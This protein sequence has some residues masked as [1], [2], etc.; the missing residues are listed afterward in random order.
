VRLFR[1]RFSGQ[2]DIYGTYDP[3][4]G[5]SWQVKAPVT[6]E[7][8]LDHLQGKRPY[9]VYLLLGDLTRAAVVDFDV[10]EFGPVLECV[11]RAQHYE[12]AMHIE[13]SKSKGFHVWSFFP[14]PGV[15]AWK[16]RCVLRH[17]LDETESPKVEIFPKQD[18]LSEDTTNCG[19]FINAPL[20]GA[21][22][23][24][25]K[26]VFL[27]PKRGLAP[28]PNQWEFLERAEAVPET[29]LDEIIQVN[30]LDRSDTDH[31]VGSP[32]NSLGVFEAGSVFPPCVHTMLRN[33]VTENQRVACFR[34][35]VHLRRVGLPYELA[36]AALTEWARK[37][38]PSQGKQII[39][40]T[41]IKAQAAS[42]FLKEYRGNGC[43]EPAVAA[44]CDPECPIRARHSL[45]TA[46]AELPQD[47]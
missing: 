4:T 1:E 46:R 28:F 25:G 35:A 12:V 22:V 29:R 9:G 45:E 26:T 3:Q 6:D 14:E 10:A 37:N 30:G 23:H 33:G 18:R 40:Q 38:R 13:R 43:E 8:V 24:Q 31:G 19:N 16:P 44:Y 42:A 15:P 21:L 41:E 36:V 32:C 5:R 47:R 7:V 11:G 2:P 17:I 20:F 39:S 27:D 34:I